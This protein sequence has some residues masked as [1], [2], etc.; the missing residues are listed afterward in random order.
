MMVALPK[1][2]FNTYQEWTV[3]EG[4]AA[5]RDLVQDPDAEVEVLNISKW[6]IN[7]VSVMSW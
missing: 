6:Q 4:K 3:E 2:P 7:E 5:F 1:D